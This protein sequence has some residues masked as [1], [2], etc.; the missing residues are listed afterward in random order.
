MLLLKHKIG[1][2]SLQN[3]FNNFSYVFFWRL[4]LVPSFLLFALDK[5]ET[6][7]SFTQDHTSGRKAQSVAR[8]T[9]EPEVP[10]PI[11]D[12]AKYFLSPSADTVV[13]Y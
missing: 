2:L 4:T 1:T 12:P 5:F 6:S 9:R 8:L 7:F 13:S 11:P 3:Y 10:V